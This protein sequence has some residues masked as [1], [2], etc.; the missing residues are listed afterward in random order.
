MSDKK[1]ILIVDDEP[2]MVEYLK[3]LYEDNGF[4]TITAADGVEG[5]AKAESNQPDL[6]SLDITMDKE[7]GTVVRTN[8]RVTVSL[9]RTFNVAKYESV[10][11][12]VGYGDDK[13]QDESIEQCFVRVENRTV[14]EFDKLVTAIETGK[15]KGTK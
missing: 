7:S 1:T 12:H 15:I 2:D 14:K 8:S 4:N 11:L 10:N 9:G 6:I 3:T 13:T 5:F